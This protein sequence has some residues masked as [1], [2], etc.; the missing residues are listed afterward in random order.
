MARLARL[1]F[2]ILLLAITTLTI[3]EV[4]AVVA[5]ALTVGADRLALVLAALAGVATPTIAALLAVLRSEAN[6]VRIQAQ[7]ERLTRAEERANGK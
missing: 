3:A 4:S 1:D 7:E 2:V 5:L 6:R